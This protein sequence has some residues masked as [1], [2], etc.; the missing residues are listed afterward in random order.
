[1]VLLVTCYQQV[2]LC[3]II[4][5][6]LCCFISQSHGHS[7]GKPRSQSHISVKGS[8]MSVKKVRTLTLPKVT[9]SPSTD[10]MACFVNEKENVTKEEHE[11]GVDEAQVVMTFLCQ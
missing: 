9:T 7:H 5:F 2:S 11:D 6:I 3:K 8:P 1:M 4:V 10:S